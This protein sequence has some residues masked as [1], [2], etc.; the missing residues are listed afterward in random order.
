RKGQVEALLLATPNDPHLLEEL[1][2]LERVIHVERKPL[3]VALLNWKPGN[4]WPGILAGALILYNIGLY[5]LITSVSTLRDEEE[6]AGWT[7]SWG[8]YGYLIWIHRSVVLLFYV[9]FASFLL[10]VAH[11]LA[12]EVVIPRLL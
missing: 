7:Q 12:E 3:W 1:A 5:V 11:M 9:S 2:R 10:N 4:P 8:E 6:R